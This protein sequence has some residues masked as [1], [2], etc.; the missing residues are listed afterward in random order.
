MTYSA[1]ENGSILDI[2]AALFPESSKRTLRQWVQFKRVFVEGEVIDKPHA[3]I[4]AG[5]SV[6]ITSETKKALG[7]PLLYKDKWL[8]AIHKP[9]GLLSVP[10]ADGADNALHKLRA[11]F[12]QPSIEPAHRIDQETSGVLLFTRTPEAKKRIMPLFSKH[13]IHR[14]YLAVVEGTS[15]PEKGTWRYFL[16][17]LPSF[18]VVACRENEGDESVTHFEVLKK[19]RHVTLL[20]LVLETGKKHQIRVHA[21]MSGHPIVGDARYGSGK[22]ERMMLHAHS[23]GFIHPFTG[24]QMLFTSP[25][26]K[27][28]KKFGITEE[29]LQAL[30][31]PGKEFFPQTDGYEE[32]LD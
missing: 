10:T 26:P 13:E 9:H 32:D 12:K 25:L 2:L 19:T 6:E 17:E 15:L 4:K 11:H 18:H 23:L 31:H 16:K 29:G 27:S 22:S 21:K 8:I 5:Q 14:E 3:Q 7:I 30:Q 24:K 1:P 28:F 20:R